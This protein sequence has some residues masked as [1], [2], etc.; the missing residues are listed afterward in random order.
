ML[1][2]RWFAV[3]LVTALW[4]AT[5]DDASA[6][7]VA[8]PAHVQFEPY[9]DVI[10]T[11]NGERAHCTT[12][13]ASIDEAVLEPEVGDT[14]TAFT[15]L[16]CGAVSIAVFRYLTTL[17]TTVRDNMSIADRAIMRVQ[18]QVL[19]SDTGDSVFLYDYELGIWLNDAR[20]R[21]IYKGQIE[22]QPDIEF[23]DFYDEYTT[24]FW[25]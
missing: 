16:H 7:I 14:A 11:R 4:L 17:G 23:V 3:T 13:D 21:W 10:T 22:D 1:R 24:S 15:Q 12:P 9:I 18:I 8:V 25:L 19:Y 5:P 2:T 6:Q 20:G